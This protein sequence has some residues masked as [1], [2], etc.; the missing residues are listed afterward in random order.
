MGTFKED[1]E[2]DLD[3]VFSTDEFGR[4]GTLRRVDT[5]A[6]I[7]VSIVALE[8][9]YSVFDPRNQVRFF[10]RQDQLGGY[11]PQPNDELD[12]ADTGFTF[13][14]L[15]VVKEETVFSVTAQRMDERQ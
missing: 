9:L 4:T 5:G 10:L 11:V 6:T 15:N 8:L 7:S 14:L 3:T 12:D 1:V 13:A 2:Y